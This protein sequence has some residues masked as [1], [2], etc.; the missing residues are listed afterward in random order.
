MDPFF[1]VTVSFIEDVPRSSD[2]D[3]TDWKLTT[4][5][6]AFKKI[7][8]FHNGETF[9]EMLHQIFKEYDIL[10]KVSRHAWI[11]QML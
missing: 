5:V 7:E 10:H 4:G 9:A 8:G 2:S 3:K 6:I 11:S 1:T